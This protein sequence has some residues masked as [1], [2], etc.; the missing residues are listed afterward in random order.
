MISRLAKFLLVITSL[1]P[2]LFVIGANKASIHKSIYP[3]LP[4]FASAI[5]LAFICLLIL[6]YAKKELEVSE[7]K[8]VSVKNSDNEVLAFLL[9][10]LLPLFA[11]D[12]LDFNGDMIT[13]A[14]ILL[15]I[16]ITV[17]HSNTYHFNPILGLFKYHFFEVTT[18]SGMSYILLT[19]KPL[20]S[21]NTVSKIV[22]LS[23]YMVFEKEK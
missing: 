6:E 21:S 15:V 10:Y 2:I 14:T 12:K 1:S 9:T 7:I 20:K 18:D 3:A 5:G 16:F 19:K 8:I 23:D 17:Y 22:H 13:C 4:W 11:Q